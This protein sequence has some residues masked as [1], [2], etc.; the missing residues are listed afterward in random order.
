MVTVESDMLRGTYV[1][2][3]GGRLLFGDYAK[4]WQ[5]T[6]MHRATTAA[7]VDSHLRIHLIPEFGSRPMGS[8]TPSEVQ[9]WVRRLS[10]RLAPTTCGVVYGHLATI[11]KSAIADQLIVHS[12]CRDI[13]LPKQH[14]KKVKPPDT[15]EV[16][17]LIEAI[18]DRYRGLTV[19]A[20]GTGLR[21]GEAF[22]LTCDHVDLR[23]REIEIVQQLVLV[24]G[25]DPFFGPPKSDSS[26]RTIPLPD[27]VVEAIKR[28][29]RDYGAGPHGLLFTNDRGEPI[30]RTRFSE[31]WRRAVGDAALVA[32]IRFHDLRHY[33]ASLLI[34]HGESVKTVQSRLGHLSATETLDTYG[35]LWPDSE[36]RTRAAVDL[37]LGPSGMTE[38]PTH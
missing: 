19:L 18:P 6:R 37:V 20:A 13:T 24:P 3:E 12:P 35:H 9:G 28:H 8:I 16:L 30:R 15:D 36:E 31:V 26:F 11:F 5:A 4:G 25:R 1:R 14:K 29:R 7:Q 21:Q 23:R 34:H 33:Y 38:A 10:K 17:A 2:P 22:G 27:F 32:G